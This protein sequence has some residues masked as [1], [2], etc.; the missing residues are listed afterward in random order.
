M[1]SYLI[2]MSTYY[3]REELDGFFSRHNCTLHKDSKNKKWWCEIGDTL[4]FSNGAVARIMDMF[5]DNENHKC[6]WIANR[7]LSGEEIDFMFNK[8][9]NPKKRLIHIIKDH[10]EITNAIFGRDC[11]GH[12]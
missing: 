5:L 1:G 6:M 2:K 3:G 11:H 10:K 4:K 7:N 9:I 8:K 12:K